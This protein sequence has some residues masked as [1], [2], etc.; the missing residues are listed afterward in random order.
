MS[1]EA[2]SGDPSPGDPA[3]DEPGSASRGGATGERPRRILLVD[4]DMFFVQVARLEDPEGAGRAELLLVG[5]SADGR[6]VVTSASYEAREYGVHSAM[7]TARALELCPDATVVPVP[8][9]ACG[10]RSREVRRVLR[11]LAP[12]V[13]AASI[14]EFYLD[15]TGTER[16][17]QGEPLEETARRIRE[18]VAEETEIGVSIGGGTTKIV[19]KL[20]TSLAKPGGVHVVPAGS[21]EAF[22]RRFDLGDIPGV[23]PALVETLEARGLRTVEEL[24]EVDERWLV[25]WLGERRGRW[26]HRR[27]RGIDPSPVRASEPRKSVSSERTFPTDLHDEEALAAELMK[28]VVSASRGLRNEGLRART[29]T[30]KVRDADFTTRQA[31]HTLPEPV[32]SERAIFSV[33][34]TLFTELR[35]RRRTGVRLLGVGLSSLQDREAPVQL[36]LFGGDAR[37]ESE[38]DRTVTRAMDA[39]RDR[40]GDASIVPGRVMDDDERKDDG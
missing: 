33:A 36:G 12:V 38:R 5:G 23:G 3:G 25:E 15:M 26:L 37:T 9:D 7:P 28:Q 10:R 40:F 24:V 16:L 4:C 18:R 1:D 8:R 2:V 32:E 17:F 11:E 29:V 35:R 39:L 34:R 21:E 27:A 20:A 22:L 30:V 19:A 6:G 31:S 14:D 13:Q